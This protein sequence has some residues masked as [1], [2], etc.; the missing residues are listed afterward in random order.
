MLQV[1][2]T[3]LFLALVADGAPLYMAAPTNAQVVDAETGLPIQGAVI[4]ANWQLV[5]G[6]LDGPRYVGQLEVKETTTDNLGR[7]HFDGFTKVNLRLADLRDED[8]RILVFKL[9]YESKM[10]FNSYPE[11]GTETPGIRRTS[12]VDGHIIRLQR[13]TPVQMGGRDV[14]YPF[15]RVSQ[16]DLMRDC[17]WE[18]IPLLLLA[19]QEA[20]REI[21]AAHPQATTGLIDIESIEISD[22]DQCG[23][24]V[25][26]L[27]AQAK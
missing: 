1:L 14:F 5:R 26:F 24:V 17:G 19:A 22:R 20:Q 21:K 3:L 16:E 10:F 11:A 2:L 8:P 6:G 23:S 9:G 7:F 12:S 15:F 25:E 13:N 27:K 18:K 4:V